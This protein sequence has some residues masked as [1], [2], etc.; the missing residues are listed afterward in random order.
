MGR[1]DK[2]VSGL[3]I[4]IVHPTN[5]P[6][7]RRGTERFMNELAAYLSRRGHQVTIL[8]SKPGRGKTVIEN[9]FT[10]RYYRSLWYPAMA[11][12]GI[13]DFHVFPLT[14]LYALIR[15]KVDI[16]HCFNFTDALAGTGVKQFNGAPVV[17]HLN[18]I[19]PPVRY[20]RSL[21][22]RGAV[23]RQAVRT[24]DEVITISQP[25]HDYFM[26]RFGRQGVRIA[27]PVDT[28]T[29]QMTD[30]RD[31]S[32]PI[33]LCASQLDDLRKGGR[34]LLRAFAQIKQRRPE[35]ILQISC[36]ISDVRR[37]ELLDLVPSQW[38]PDVQ[39]LGVG[40]VDTLP[41]LFG[42]AAVLVVPSLWE[43]FSLALLESLSVGTP[44]VANN[45]T[46][47]RVLHPLVGRSFD[48]GPPAGGEPTNLEGL[49]QAILEAI[50]LSRRPETRVHCRATAE[51]FSWQMI[52]PRF[53]AIY[54]EVLQRSA[55][56]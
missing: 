53:E 28:D 34:L 29:F 32:R 6:Y 33:I 14:T 23:L 36:S 17:L 42:R 15:E 47:S 1:E 10:T 2:S 50:E 4:A 5:W 35:A 12:L 49:T 38:R 56:A 30:G 8:C 22:M 21:T 20:R 44:I 11:R 48:P 3:R 52:G 41:Q 37:R 46:D 27:A 9:G 25:Q 7:V 43:V 40:D 18:T 55:R 45:E 24:A 31:H 39:F 51:Q 19:P 26:N 54:R 13:L 16:V